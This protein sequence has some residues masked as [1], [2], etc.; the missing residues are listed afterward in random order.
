MS[1]KQFSDLFNASQ[2]SVQLSEWQIEGK[3]EF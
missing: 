1:Q 2:Q 3:A